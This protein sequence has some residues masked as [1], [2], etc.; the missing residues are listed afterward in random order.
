MAAVAAFAFWIEPDLLGLKSWLV[1]LA[2]VT[3][4]EVLVAAIISKNLRQELVVQFQREMT[5]S[6]FLAWGEV[7]LFVVFVVVLALRRV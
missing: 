7:A 4:L 1:C 3:G 6:V 2:I 5:L